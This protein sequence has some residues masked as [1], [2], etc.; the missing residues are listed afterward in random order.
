MVDYKFQEE[1]IQGLVSVIIPTH[2]RAHLISETIF[3]ILGQSYK[4]IEIIIVD[5]HSI[6]NIEDIVANFGQNTV[7]FVKS[8]NLGA[9]AARNLGLLYS[10]GE[11]IQFFDDDDIMDVDHIRKKVDFLSA[12]S[13]YDYVCCNFL[14]FENNL[15]NIVGE[16][17]IDSIEH[18]I[19]C[20]LLN[21]GFPAPTFFC[22]RKA[23]MAIGFWN[24][25]C[26]RF[27]D[28]CYFHR[29][30]LKRLKGY[31]LSEYL[32]KVRVHSEKISN[33][34]S[35]KFLSSIF[36]SFE[37]IRHEWL[38]SEVDFCQKRKICIAISLNEYDTCFKALK[39][40]HFI[41]GIKHFLKISWIY[42]ES[43][44]FCLKYFIKRLLFVNRRI[45]AFDLLRKL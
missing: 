29:L 33:N 39:K 17:R 37:T 28:T 13:Y 41:W 44:F 1:G 32:F 4:N 40:K 11:Y 25:S 27:Q 10:R 31:W 5:D 8:P 9:C 16:K 3:S 45:T 7:V 6:D 14:Y 21:S 34:F 38:L 24:E 12:N 20:H 43:F 42:P 30:F 23:I 2:N 22:R 18:T 36:H 26:L 19:E 35:V 15:A